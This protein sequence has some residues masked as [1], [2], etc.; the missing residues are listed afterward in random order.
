[1]ASMTKK[2]L[3]PILAFAGIAGCVGIMTSCSSRQVIQP[4]DQ[5]PTSIKLEQTV[6][7]VNPSGDTTEVQPGT[8][9]VGENQGNLQLIGEMMNS[10]FSLRAHPTTHEESLQTPTPLSFSEQEDEHIIMLLHPDGTALEAA[11]SYSGIQSRAIRKRQKRVSRAVIKRRFNRAVLTNRARLTIQTHF[12]LRVPIQLNNLDSQ[13]NKL[14]I[15]CWTHSGNDATK[16]DRRIGEGES[17]ANISDRQFNGT[18]VVKFNASQGK[19]P[20]QADRYYCGITLHKIGI[21]FRQPVK[22][23]HPFANSAPAWR[24][25]ADGSPFRIHAQGGV[26]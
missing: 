11:G 15:R 2:R 9:E 18:V 4:T 23:G 19:E 1:M 20:E 21:G 24:I 26:N 16:Y 7:F 25:S 8:Y 13:I 5:L 10:P 3:F 17:V 14:K 12:T 22:H 6:H